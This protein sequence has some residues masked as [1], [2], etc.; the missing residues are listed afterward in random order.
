[1]A[2]L[3][4]A[5]AIS[6]LPTTNYYNLPDFGVF[7]SVQMHIDVLYMC[8]FFSAD[9][10]GLNRMVDSKP[11]PQNQA[12]QLS[13]QGKLLVVSNSLFSACIRERI[14]HAIHLNN[15]INNRGTFSQHYEYICQY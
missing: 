14:Q 2:W 13:I 6:R 12:L 7:F 10:Y 9:K 3:L 8:T 15:P 1:M 4:S 5:A 11:Q